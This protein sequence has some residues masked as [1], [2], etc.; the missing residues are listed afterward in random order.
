MLK[1]ESEIY[2]TWKRSW[3]LKK[4]LRKP[5]NI[6]VERPESRLPPR[7]RYFPSGAIR[8]APGTTHLI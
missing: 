6:R 7:Y 5:R 1:M 2:L 3:D 8:E 4:M